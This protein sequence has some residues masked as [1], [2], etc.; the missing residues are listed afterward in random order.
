M[1]FSVIYLGTCAKLIAIRKAQVFTIR[2]SGLGQPS[3][4]Y[5]K[6]ALMRKSQVT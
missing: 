6:P 3:S 2:I 1:F 4:H 5:E